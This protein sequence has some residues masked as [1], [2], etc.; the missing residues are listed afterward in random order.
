MGL[1]GE[2]L[3]FNEWHWRS[4]ELSGDHWDSVGVIAAQ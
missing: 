1:S 4:L 3:A 2:S